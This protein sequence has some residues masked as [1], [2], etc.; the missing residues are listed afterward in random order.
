VT[1]HHLYNENWN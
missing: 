1:E